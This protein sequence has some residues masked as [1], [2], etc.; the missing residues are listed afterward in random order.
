MMLRQKLFS[1][2]IYLYHLCYWVLNH[3]ESH[4]TRAHNILSSTAAPYHS[5][6][7][8]MW[9]DLSPGTGKGLP[10]LSDLN[11]DIFSNSF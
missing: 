8:G 11:E 7:S 3:T 6:C 1:L 5:M 2:H 4:E 9:E 10:T